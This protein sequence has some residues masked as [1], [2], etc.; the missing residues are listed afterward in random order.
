MRIRDQMLCDNS[1]LTSSLHTVRAYA[2]PFHS[3][4]RYLKV[5]KGLVISNLRI[6][7]DKS[8]QADVSA[9]LAILGKDD[10]VE[11]CRHSNVG[12]TSNDLVADPPLAI[13]VLLGQVQRSSHDANRRVTSSQTTAEVLKVSPVISVE[14]LA[15]LRAHVAQGKRIVHG[16]LRPFGIGS[17]HLVA[18]IIAAT[19][20]VLELSTE[21]FWNGLVLNKDRVLAVCVTILER[22][23]SDVLDNP[24]RVPCSAVVCRGQGRGGSQVGH[25]ARESI[26]VESIR[27]DRSGSSSK[28]FLNT[29]RLANSQRRVD[30]SREGSGG[31]VDADRTCCFAREQGSCGCCSECSAAC[32]N[33]CERDLGHDIFHSL[34]RYRGRRLREQTATRLVGAL[35]KSARD[36]L[37][38]NN[39]R[40]A[41]NVQTHLQVASCTTMQEHLR[42]VCYLL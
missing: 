6:G 3:F 28:S 15:D 14:A 5:L 25:G 23:G 18:S 35:Q 37:A 21:L 1:Q 7:Q 20:V 38:P 9:N 4:E 32:G 10:L 19:E 8:T 13:C 22:L 34:D 31:S 29:C 17:R 36:A 27:V 24:C 41:I 12:R 40:Q 2:I 30:G 26:L 42:W 39:L 16:L 11:V 33:E